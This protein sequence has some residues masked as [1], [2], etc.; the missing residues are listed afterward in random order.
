MSIPSIIG[1][2]IMVFDLDGTITPSKSSMD[3][4]MASLFSKVLDHMMIAVITG[5][6]FERFAAQF[7]ELQCPDEKMRRFSFF[8]TSGTR[9]YRYT[10][11][12]EQVYADEMTIE[13][14]QKIRDA[15]EKAYVDIDYCHPEVVYGEILEDRGTQMTFSACGQDAPLEVKMA[16]KAAHNDRRLALAD[17]V[18]KYLPDFEVNVPGVT[19][20]DVTRKGIDKA[21]GIAKI[22]EHLGIAIDEMVFVGDALYE[23]GN[24]YPVIR[25]G[26]DTV[27]VKEPEE[28]KAVIRE[29]LKELSA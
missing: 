16:F 10:T 18:R 1:K 25:T 2:K 27:A 7:Q 23:G 21:Y 14:R 26:I 22:Q 8:P 12:W 6:G 20:I 13:E 29:W 11:E 15:F 28:T 3:T 19:S 9:Y 4:E 5:G 17:A 24:D